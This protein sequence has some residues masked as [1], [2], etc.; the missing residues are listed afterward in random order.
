V[1]KRRRRRAPTPPSQTGKPHDIL[2]GSRRTPWGWGARGVR[3]WPNSN[4]CLSVHARGLGA[5]RLRRPR[6]FL[7]SCAE[8]DRV[9]ESRAC[10]SYVNRPTNT[11][12]VSCR[13]SNPSGETQC[14][15]GVADGSGCFSLPKE[16][17]PQRRGGQEFPRELPRRV[18]ACGCSLF[19]AIS[20]RPS[21]SPHHLFRHCFEITASTAEGDYNN[22]AVFTNGGKCHAVFCFEVRRT[23]CTFENNCP[24]VAAHPHVD[25]RIV[26]KHL[27]LPHLE[28]HRTW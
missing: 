5:L 27:N 7:D 9:Q 12:G 25:A 14:A 15:S 3:P 16:K 26:E 22:I 20:E 2:R 21:G 28:R 13:D 18:G 10:G 23:C 4:I 1:C 17:S 19:A 6:Y 11:G 24:R 8:L